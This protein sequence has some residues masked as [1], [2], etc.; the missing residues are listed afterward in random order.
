MIIDVHA[1]IG[2]LGGRLYSADTLASYLDA[3]QVKVV[4][5]SHTDHDASGGALDEVDI[6][7]AI[8]KTCEPNPNMLPVY[9]A[10]PGQ[11]DSN[12][13]AFSGALLSN[14]FVAATFSPAIHGYEPHD[15]ARLGPYLEVLSGLGRPALLHLGRSA[16]A[17]GHQL[18]AMASRWPKLPIILVNALVNPGRTSLLEAVAQAGRR[19]EA[20]LYVETGHA[21][22]E[23]VAKAVDVV[24]V[25]RVLFGSDAC[26]DGETHAA[27]VQAL[28]ESTH[29]RLGATFV[30]QIVFSN[31]QRI[32]QLRG[33]RAQ[34][35]PAD[36]PE[37]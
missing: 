2:S 23:E 9:W 14:P 28:L 13:R 5:V 21:S 15:I 10:R 4:M 12:A 17:S 35:R 6:N 7:T 3:C 19:G 11:V 20:S 36:T 27:G 8:L 18:L 29:S 24:G 25:G 31:P 26:H 37:S 32:F 16:A 30:S 22:A 1:H 33:G 34:D